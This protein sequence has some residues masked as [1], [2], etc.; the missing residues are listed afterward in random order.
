MGATT[1]DE[2]ALPPASELRAATVIPPAR[3]LSVRF[4]EFTAFVLPTYENHG[5]VCARTSRFW[6]CRFAVGSAAPTVDV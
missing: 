1:H 3:Q 5:V 6:R 2:V 4:K